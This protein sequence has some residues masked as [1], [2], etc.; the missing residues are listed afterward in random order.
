MPAQKRRV[1]AKPKPAKRAAKPSK[2]QSGWQRD[3]QGM[4]Q[5]ILDAAMAEFA[6]HGLGGAR[7]DRIAKAAGANKRMIYYHVGDKE[8]L[9]LVILEATY[10]RIRVAE[11]RLN[12]EA[13]GPR[14]AI[15]RLLAFTWQYYIDNPEFLALL[16][17]ENLHRARY[18]RKSR[19]V[20]DM[21]SP[22][23]TLIADILQR[24]ER[25]GDVRPGIDPVQLYISIAGLCYFYQSNSA[26]LGTIFGRDLLEQGARDERLAHMTDLLIA[27]ISPATSASL[28]KAPDVEFN[29]R[30]KI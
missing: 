2:R 19:K 1:R 29:Q 3:P 27:A 25:S 6:R 30:V 13:L 20:K 8:A 24:G 4:R 15:A 11:R 12:L 18:L 23:V 22:F 9:Y 17:E 10:E 14:A 28:D 21:H 26:T 7:I 16:N 5:R